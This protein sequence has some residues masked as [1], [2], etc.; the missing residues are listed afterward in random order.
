MRRACFV[1]AVSLAWRIRASGEPAAALFEAIKLHGELQASAVPERVHL[2]DGDGLKR[3]NDLEG[4]NAA[5]ERN[6]AQYK[7]TELA[8][9]RVLQMVPNIADAI[10]LFAEF[11]LLN[12]RFDYVQ[13][14]HALIKQTVSDIMGIP[15]GP[16]DAVN[17]I[18]MPS[19]KIITICLRHIKAKAL[20][21]EAMSLIRETELHPHLKEPLLKE[22]LQLQHASF[23]LYP[24]FHTNLNYNMIANLLCGMVDQAYCSLIRRKLY[25]PPLTGNQTVV[26]GGPAALASFQEWLHGGDRGV[27]ELRQWLSATTQSFE[28]PLRSSR[29]DGGAH[30]HGGDE[31]YAR[32][33]RCVFIEVGVGP[34]D[35]LA[36]HYLN[37]SRWHGVSVEPLP[38]YLSWLP[39][40]SIRLAKVAAAIDAPRPGAG[41]GG[42]AASGDETTVLYVVDSD[43]MMHKGMGSLNPVH[44]EG[45]L[46]NHPGKKRA[47]TVRRE[48]FAAMLARPAVY[49]QLCGGGDV[50]GAG[51]GDY[52]VYHPNRCKIDLLKLDTEGWDVKVLVQ[53]LDFAERSGVWPRRIKFEY[54]HCEEV[55]VSLVTAKLA[56]SGYFCFFSVQDIICTATS[57]VR[58]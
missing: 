36:V 50:G 13:A 3:F 17:K 10:H 32:E 55:E 5:A 47:V 44:H 39:D 29:C 26:R 4:E 23:T 18:R 24:G 48:T 34:H 35:S 16:S 51:D 27:E 30:W 1:V 28:P 12:L 41:G 54:I 8:Y 58:G 43:V 40:E 25:V 11:N 7:L 42:A 56:R 45:K 49:A 31:G 38:E 22:A 52:V 2:M 19:G 9:Q 53:V 6:N 15:A 20:Q 37:D 14:D 57:H 33:E 46:F 21:Y